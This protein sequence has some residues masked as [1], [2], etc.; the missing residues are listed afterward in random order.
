M[1]EWTNGWLHTRLAVVMLMN[2]EQEAMTLKQEE[3][4][5]HLVANLES[6]WKAAWRAT[7]HPKS[8][9][10]VTVARSD[11]LDSKKHGDAGPVN[12][13]AAGFNRYFLGVRALQLQ[14]VDNKDYSV[15]WKDKF[16]TL[17]FKKT[18]PSEGKREKQVILCIIYTFRRGWWWQDNKST[19]LL[20]CQVR[21]LYPFLGLFKC[22]MCLFQTTDDGADSYMLAGRLA[23]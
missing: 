18:C 3:L 13:A 2:Y 11:K 6:D 9:P 15:R 17:S 14:E 4:F 23:T 16:T 5:I 22:S 21:R 7:E 12:L 20:H 10:L 1:A 8:H 19:L